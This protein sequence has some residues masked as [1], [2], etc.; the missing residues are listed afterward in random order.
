MPMVYTNTM[1]IA[2]YIY[3]GEDLGYPYIQTTTVLCDIQTS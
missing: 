3:D 2:Q 1:S